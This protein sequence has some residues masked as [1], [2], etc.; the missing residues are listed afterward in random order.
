MPIRPQPG[1]PLLTERLDLRVPDAAD[2]EDLWEIHGDP[3]TFALDSTRP[4]ERREQMRAVLAAWLADRARDGFG[5]AT[6]RLRPGARTPS[7]LHGESEPATVGPADALFGTARVVGVCGLTR[8]RLAGSGEEILS[9]YYRF[10]PEVQGA[11][12][13]TEAL[14]A[15]LAEAG[16]ELG[17]REAVV[18]TDPANAPSRA[19]A[20]RLGFAA[21]DRH[22]PGK[23]GRIVLARTLPAPSTKEPA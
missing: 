10:R 14:G 20:E 21:T 17:P 5:Y 9:V 1:S 2:L 22:G 3:R 12:I 4:L 23:G 11:G 7:S 15:L 8:H 16:R 18:V 13:A 19:L 6:V